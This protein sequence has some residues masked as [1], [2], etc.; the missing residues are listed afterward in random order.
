MKQEIINTV[1][2]DTRIPHK[3]VHPNYEAVGFRAIINAVFY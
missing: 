3:A 1:L 2:F